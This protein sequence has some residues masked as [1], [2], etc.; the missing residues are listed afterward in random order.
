MTSGEFILTLDATNSLEATFLEKALPHFE[1]SS[2]AA[3]SGT[4]NSYDKLSS[5]SRWRSRHLFHEDSPN[6]TAEPCSMLITYGTLLRR[7]AIE[8][9]GGFD[10]MR[11]FKEDQEMGERLADAGYTV[12]GDPAIKI[13]PNIINSVPQ[14]L[15]RYARWHMDPNE[16]P[17]FGGYLHNIKASFK[18]MIQSDLKAGDWSSALISLLAPHFQLYHGIKAYLKRKNEN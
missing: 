10:K 11:R 3:V 6:A 1:E 14:L 7:K 5:T 16:K 18:P 9:V 12:I 2:V 13:F 17:N 15:E 8:Q 4:L